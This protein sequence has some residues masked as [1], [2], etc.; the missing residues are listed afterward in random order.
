LL[1][2]AWERFSR[3]EAAQLR[4]PAEE[5][6]Q[7]ARQAADGRA[8]ADAQMLVG[9]VHAAQGKLEVAHAAF[10]QC[11]AINRRLAAQDPGNA[12]WQR[13]LA[14]TYLAL[15]R[16]EAR[17]ERHEAALGRYEQAVRIY[18]ELAETGRTNEQWT[19][20]RESA[21]SELA[22]LRESMP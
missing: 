19:S 8:E 11:L 9:D 2:I 7:L 20:E 4:Q 15:A 22:R 17:A 1:T 12:G 16:V 3:G 14:V 10:G 13:D 18:D 5:A 6:L 21:A